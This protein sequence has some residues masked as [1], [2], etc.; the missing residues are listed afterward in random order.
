MGGHVV[1]QRTWECE[2]NRRMS[3]GVTLP[4]DVLVEQPSNALGAWRL[5]L[6]C[7]FGEAQNERRVVLAQ[8]AIELS[9]FSADE[10]SFL[11]CRG[12]KRL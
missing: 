12:Q 11:L 10:V 7:F 9:Y 4:L 3:L 6:K 5:A 2:G 1:L 8:Q